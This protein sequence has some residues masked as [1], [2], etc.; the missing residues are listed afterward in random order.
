MG[1]HDQR[2]QCNDVAVRC[3]VSRNGIPSTTASPATSEAHA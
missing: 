3:L 1:Q 2:K